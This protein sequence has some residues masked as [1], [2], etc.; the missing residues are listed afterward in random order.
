MSQHQA[1]QLA[2]D[3]TR[4]LDQ[5]LPGTAVNVVTLG[6]VLTLPH[7]AITVEPPGGPVLTYSP[8][9][10]DDGSARVSEEALCAILVTIM[11]E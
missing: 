10:L 2:D 1:T 7:F 9:D 3:L 4:T 8:N 5:M 11:S 6:E